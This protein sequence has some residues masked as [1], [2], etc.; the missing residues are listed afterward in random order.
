V[1]VIP[2][3]SK[4]LFPH[5]SG[6][7]LAGDDLDYAAKDE[8]RRVGIFELAAGLE[9]QLAPRDGLHDLRKPL[10]EPKS[11]LAGHRWANRSG[12]SAD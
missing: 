1:S 8:Q 2:S 11:H 9:A 12:A 10:L 6:V 3:G 7:R 4:N 5:V